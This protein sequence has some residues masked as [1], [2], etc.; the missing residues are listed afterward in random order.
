M[1]VG[2]APPTRATYA[3]DGHPRQEVGEN[4]GATAGGYDVVGL[5][6]VMSIADGAAAAAAGG[7]AVTAG[8]VVA[9]A[10]AADTAMAIDGG[11]GAV[12][13][14][15]QPASWRA[16]QGWWP[17]GPLATLAGRRGGC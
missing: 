14:K 11:Q 5:A 10:A 15:L 9:E 8:A 1:G 3:D 7:G 4:P 12:A 2:L 16:C 13:Q 17:G 6:A